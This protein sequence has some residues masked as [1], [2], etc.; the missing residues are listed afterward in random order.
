[1][2]APRR[3]Y[4][5]FRSIDG[6]EIYAGRSAE[7]NDELSLN[8]DHRHDV[9]MTTQRRLLSRIE[10]SPFMVFRLLHKSPPHAVLTCAILC[11]STIKYLLI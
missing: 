1:M 4:Y 10:F 3:P 2:A 9:S 7:E 11:S 6:I 5:V 8:P